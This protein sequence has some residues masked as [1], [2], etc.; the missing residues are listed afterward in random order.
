MRHLEAHIAI[1][2]E[3][4]RQEM[5]RPYASWKTWKDEANNNNNKEKKNYKLGYHQYE[6][7]IN[8]HCF[9]PTETPELTHGGFHIF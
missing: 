9:A 3:T 7:H 8:D 4:P 6:A 1:D 5:P 2:L